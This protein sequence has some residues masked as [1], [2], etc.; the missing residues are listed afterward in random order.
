[1]LLLISAQTRSIC[2]FSGFIRQNTLLKKDSIPPDSQLSQK[3]QTLTGFISRH[4]P[5]DFN[6]FLFQK[7]ML[8]LN[9]TS[10]SFRQEWIGTGVSESTDSFYRTRNFRIITIIDSITSL[11]RETGISD[12][13]FML[14]SLS[15]SFTGI[16][17]G[18]DSIYVSSIR[19][20]SNNGIN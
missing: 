8:L 15:V 19:I 9:H 10:L 11:Y 13:Y 14:H 18:V 1:M 17:T 3:Q 2:T 20:S 4:L 16:S 6:L 5:T 12:N 7:W